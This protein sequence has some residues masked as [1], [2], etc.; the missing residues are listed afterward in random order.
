MF[1]NTRFEN[2]LSYEKT[3]TLKLR[4]NYIVERRVISNK[5]SQLRVL[6]RYLSREIPRTSFLQE[7]QTTL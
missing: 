3:R 1:K 7:V 2:H 5:I 6:E 4:F